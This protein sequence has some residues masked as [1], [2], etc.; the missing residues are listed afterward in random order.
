M[1]PTI[2]TNRYPTLKNIDIPSALLLPSRIITHHPKAGLNPLADAA[3]YLFTMLGKLK[4]M[5]S[6]RQLNKLQKKLVREISVFQDSAKRSGYN[7]EYLLVCRFVI[8]AAFDDIISNTAWG[9]QGQWQ[10]YSL[11]AAFNQDVQHQDK[12]F[13][14]LERAIKEPAHYIDLMELIYLCLSLGYKGR[15]RS[16][17]YSQYQLEQITDNLYKHIRAYRGSFNKTLSPVPLKAIKTNLKAVSQRGVAVFDITF[18]TTCII[19]TIFISLGYLT[20]V[21]SNEAYKNI[22]H[23]ENSVSHVANAS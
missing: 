23:I 19:M 5:D 16:T 8:C 14:I 11:L 10:A 2:I 22:A 12:F 13:S 4:L 20:D 7:A 15:Y 9:S 6:Y 3:S 1:T 21:I 17:E 18:I